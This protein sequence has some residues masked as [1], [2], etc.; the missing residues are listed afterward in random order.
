MQVVYVFAL[1]VSEALRTPFEVL[2]LSCLDVRHERG[3]VLDPC[4]EYIACVVIGATRL[5]F[6]KVHCVGVEFG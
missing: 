3:E 6:E 2:P 1:E 4:A 5:P